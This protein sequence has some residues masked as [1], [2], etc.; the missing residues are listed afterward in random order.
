MGA[1][2]IPTTRHFAKSQDERHA[3]K[4]QMTKSGFKRTPPSEM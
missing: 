4:L 3:T 1:D 2:N